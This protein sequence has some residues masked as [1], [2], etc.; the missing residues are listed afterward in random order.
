[1]NTNTLELARVLDS[2]RQNRMPTGYVT[3]SAPADATDRE[4][5][6]VAGYCSRH[7]GYSVT[8]HDDG[9]ATVALWN[10]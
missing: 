4:L 8:R 2:S 6:E 3:V 5:A 1:M 9:T 7:F 10:D